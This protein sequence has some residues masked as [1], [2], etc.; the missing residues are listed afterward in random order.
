VPRPRR[1]ADPRYTR[2]MR[3]VLCLAVLALPLFADGIPRQEYRERRAK[4]Q[5]SLEG[6][7]VLF[8][9]DERDELRDGFFQENDFLYLS[10]W[11]SPGAILLLTPKEEILFIPP[12]NLRQENYTGRKLGPDDA[13]AAEKTGFAKVLPSYA[14]QSNFLRVLETSRRV[15]VKPADPQAP[16]LKQLAPFH[17]EGN[18][19]PLLAR[20]R[21]NK[22]P[23]EIELISK[24]SDASVAAH[25]AAWKAMRAGLYEFEIASVMTGVYNSRGCERNAYAPIVGSGPNGTILHYSA[26]K[27][28]MDSGELVVMDVGGECSDYATDITRTVP[29]NG[30]FTARQREIYEIVLGAQKAAIAAIKPGV[31]MS[32]PES[33]NQIAKD[34]INAHGKDLHG[35]PLGKYFIHGLGHSVGLDVHDPMEADAPLRAGMIITIEPGIYIPE[36]SLGVRIE[37]TIL[38]TETGAKLLSGALPREIEEIEKLVGK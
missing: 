2:N 11:R 36:E 20:L 35:Q 25:L 34:Y 27:R 12:R 23:A 31:R 14:L 18:L 3:R 24:S 7:M 30:K 19:T 4:L 21:S 8:G 9:A 22:S 37:D 26:N 10:G 13:D 1:G 38:V 15:Y 28:R 6:V 17:E 5:Q 29:V 32:G 33:L 16:R